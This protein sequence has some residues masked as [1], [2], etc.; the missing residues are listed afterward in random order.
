MNLQLC[1]K[2]TF[3]SS[4]NNGD[5]QSNTLRTTKLEKTVVIC[6]EPPLLSTTAVLAKAPDA[7]KH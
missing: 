6:D 3:G 1:L 7:G 5:I 4:S 2:I